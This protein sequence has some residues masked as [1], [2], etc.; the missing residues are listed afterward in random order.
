MEFSDP[1][2]DD[3]ALSIEHTLLAGDP[4]SS[5]GE[6]GASVRALTQRYSS[7]ND[8]LRAEQTTT[9][10]TLALGVAPGLMAALAFR[11]IGH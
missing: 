7:L 3:L 10:A 5:R 1:N 6:C 2:D 8:A 11:A 9:V 4:Q